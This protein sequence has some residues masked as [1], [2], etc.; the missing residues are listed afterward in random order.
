MDAI[1]AGFSQ[2][3]AF[4]RHFVAT[5]PSP[6]LPPYRNATGIGYASKNYQKGWEIQLAIHP[7]VGGVMQASVSLPKLQYFK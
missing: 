5:H 6:T 2:D 1:L 3:I 7:I 4:A